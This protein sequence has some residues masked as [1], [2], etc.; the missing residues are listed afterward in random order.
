M[1]DG[2]NENPDTKRGLDSKNHLLAELNFPSQK[3]Q[4]QGNNK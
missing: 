2:M 3:P 4:G 1:N